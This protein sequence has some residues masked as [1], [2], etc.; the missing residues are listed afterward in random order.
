[1]HHFDPTILFI[2]IIYIFFQVGK[3]KVT[4]KRGL[5]ILRIHCQNSA[6]IMT[7]GIRKVKKQ[8]NS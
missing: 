2:F 1:M 4:A 7:H 6:I 3:I 8:N 5:E